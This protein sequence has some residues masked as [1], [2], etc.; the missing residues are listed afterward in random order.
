MQWLDTGLIII[1][2]VGIA[3][4]GLVF[5]RFVKGTRDY[6][7]ADRKLPWW[8]I[9]LSINGTH[10]DTAD[11]VAW[12]GQGFVVGFGMWFAGLGIATG[13]FFLG[14]IM[15]PAYWLA[16]VTTTPEW[17]S[18]RLNEPTG[19]LVLLM[20]I[21]SRITN[22]A[23]ILFAGSLLVSAMTG[24]DQNFAIILL[25]T[26]AAVY[27]ISGGLRAVVYT[28]TIQTTLMWAGII[29][30]IPIAWVALGGVPGLAK[31]AATG[32][33]LHF[34]NPDMK[35]L[36]N[37]WIFFISNVAI[38]L[39]YTGGFQTCVQRALGGHGIHHARGG[40]FFAGPLWFWLVGLIG[41]VGVLGH[42]LYPDIANPDLLYPTMVKDLLPVGLTGL[43][44][45]GYLGA[46]MGTADSMSHSMSTLITKDIYERY[47]V[48]NAPDTHYLLVAR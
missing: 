42:S 10:I 16:K 35:T 5:S 23:A 1:Y 19:V 20:Q 41:T 13:A 40:A 46:V 26:I 14:W 29:L 12:S 6:Y 34:V 25:G 9:G 32:V 47:I 43:V 22:M 28:Y 33:N 4:F 15:M 27:T 48:K 36:P 39:G 45:I 24:W 38:F 37:G 21:I 31:A 8:A 44:I 11:I 2:L 30:M 17:L 18:R 3:L 7:L